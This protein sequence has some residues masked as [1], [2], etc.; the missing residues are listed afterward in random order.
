MLFHNIKDIYSLDLFTEG[1]LQL[2]YALKIM[3]HTLR[4]YFVLGI[5]WI[6]VSG[7]I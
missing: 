5:D 2:F 1:R 7:R 3:Y 6:Y 4:L